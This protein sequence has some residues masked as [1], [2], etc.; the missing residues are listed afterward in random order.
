MTEPTMEWYREQS[1][2]NRRFYE[3]LQAAW[4][5]DLHDWKVAALFYS[6]LHRVNCHFVRLTGRAPGNHFERNQRVEKEMPEVFKT[7]RNLYLMSL[8]ARYRDGLRTR[9][10]HR[11]RALALLT[12]LER[13]LPFA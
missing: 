12:Q 4:P 3:R 2:Y 8:Q 13:A 9:D 6:A 10:Y 5:D 7:Y 11:G 1:E